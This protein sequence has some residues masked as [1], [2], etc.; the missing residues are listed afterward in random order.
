MIVCVTGATGFIGAHVANLVAET[1]GP[2][3]VTFR[4]EARLTG[5]GDVEVE[6]IRADALDRGALRRAFRGCEIVFHATGYVASRPP[7]RVWQ[8]NALAPRIAVEAAAAEGVKRVVVTS[9][10]AG[11]GPAPADRP[12]TEDDVYRGGGLGLTY[13][14]AKH[15]GES[16]AFAAGARLGVEVV[17]VNPSYVFGTPIDRSRPGETSTRMVGNYLRG[18]LPAVVDGETNAVDVRDVARG[19]LRA[20]ERGRSGERYVLGGHDVRWVELLER[21][22]ELSGVRHP[23]VVLPAEAGAAVRAVRAL[24]LPMPG[25]SEGIVLMA[26]NWRYSSAKARRELGHRARPLDR[27]LKDT[28]D[29]YKE[30]IDGGALGGAPP[31]PMSLAAAGVRLAGRAGV[32]GGVQAA[33]RYIGRR[34]VLRP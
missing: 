14:D 15:E 12:G 31:S 24:G 23:L 5:L 13:P 18:R 11:I 19:H 29:W 17:V 2:P 27:T 1:Y 6:P 32:L 7:E 21:V 3:R 9:S 34:L 22:A 20:A 33:E 8:M 10:V 30:L 16:E 26:Q 4:D 28:I 25:V